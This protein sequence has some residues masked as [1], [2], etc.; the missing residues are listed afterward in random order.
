MNG[1]KIGSNTRICDS[2]IP[3]NVGITDIMKCIC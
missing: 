1:K 3:D 2:N